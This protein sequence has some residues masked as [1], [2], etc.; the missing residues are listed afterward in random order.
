MQ[1]S[2][3]CKVGHA[4]PAFKSMAWWNGKHQELSLDQFKGKYVVLFF[5]PAD[6]TFVCPTEIVQFSDKSP[7]FDKIG[8]QVIACSTDTHH[9]HKEYA[10]KDRKKGGLDPMVIPMLG[11]RTTQISADYGCLCQIPGGDAG[12]AYRATYIIDKEGK[13]RHMSIGD[14]PVGRNVDEF[15][16][17]VQA[18]QYADEYGEVCPSKWKPGAATMNPD[19]EGSKT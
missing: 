11:D 3:V 17:L 16:R 1:P 12:C 13:L 10:K 2:Q 6:F 4:A 15:F 19:H 9:S 18:F 7:E 8:C 5:Y 14:M